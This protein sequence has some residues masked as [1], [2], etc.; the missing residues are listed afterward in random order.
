MASKQETQTSPIAN[1]SFKLFKHTSMNSRK[2]E[3][4]GVLDALTLVIADFADRFT[5]PVIGKG[6]KTFA[7]Y[8]TSITDNIP[9]LRPELSL[10]ICLLC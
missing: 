7:F 3:V 6:G 2:L 10:A 1:L 9:P 4:D 8:P 5:H